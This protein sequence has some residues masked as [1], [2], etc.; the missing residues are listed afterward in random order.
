MSNTYWNEN[1]KFE[2]IAKELESLVPSMGKA[3]TLKG[4]IFR[5]ATKIYYDYH[6]NGFGNNWVAPALF[7]MNYVKLDNKIVQFLYE[8]G[9]GN[10]H[11]NSHNSKECIE[12]LMDTVILYLSSPDFQDT[13]DFE[14]MWDFDISRDDEAR[15]VVYEDEDDED[16]DYDDY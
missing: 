11:S 7:L 12:G 2:S 8:Y 5:A 4:E 16:E 10:C 15:F 14:D 3:E 13:F 1:G 6:N 9:A